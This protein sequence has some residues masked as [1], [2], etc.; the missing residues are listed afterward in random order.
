MLLGADI[1]NGVY[2]SGPVWVFGYVRPFSR[3]RHGDGDWV[4]R[5]D[6]DVNVA[7]LGTRIVGTGGVIVGRVEAHGLT[8][9]GAFGNP[10]GGL[11]LTSFAA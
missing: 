3:F 4:L 2:V 7:A 9:E 5:F 8:I 11:S 1:V 10:P 6:I